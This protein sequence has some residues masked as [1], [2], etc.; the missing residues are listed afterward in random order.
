MNKVVPKPSL[1]TQTSK[2]GAHIFHT[3]DFDHLIFSYMEIE[4][5]PDTTV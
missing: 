2:I 5:T 1:H 3:S 4:L